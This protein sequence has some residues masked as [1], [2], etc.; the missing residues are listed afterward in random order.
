[1]TH[2]QIVQDWAQAAFGVREMAND[3]VPT[4]GSFLDELNLPKIVAGPAGE[5]IARLIGGAV[6]IPAA[7]LNQVAQGFKDKTEA[8]TLVSKAVADAAAGLARNDPEVVQRAAHA[9]LSKELRHQTNRE[10]IARKVL[11]KLSE[12]PD[13]Q[14]KKIEDD[15]LNVFERYAEALF[16]FLFTFCA[17]VGALE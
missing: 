1:M 9:L 17:R 2:A 13:V 10:A 15:W 4:G 6:D 3:V 8:K 7:W 16:E 14:A 12:D 11:K 5:A